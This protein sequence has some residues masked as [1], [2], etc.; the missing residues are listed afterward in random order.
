VISA[1]TVQGLWVTGPLSPMEELSVRSFLAHGHDYDLY[2]YD[3]SLAVPAGARLL[4]AAGVLDA[5]ELR[6][7]GSAAGSYSAFSNLFRF[8]LLYERGGWWADMDMICLRPL[9][10]DDEHVFASERLPDGGATITSG[11]LKAPARSGVCAECFERARRHEGS[12]ATPWG[13]TGPALLREVVERRGATGSVLAPEVFCPVDWW[14]AETLLAPGEPPA[15]SYTVHLW[16]EVWRR[17]GWPKEPVYP[18]ATLYQRLH[19]LLPHRRPDGVRRVGAERGNGP[20]AR[21]QGFISPDRE[22]AAHGTRTRH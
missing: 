17:N 8:K 11:I 4:P 3:D 2:S 12:A 6:G 7:D 14:Q 5:G 19:Q 10:L 18:P 16:Q 13:A 15:G 20:R 1:G 21:R 22:E 9:D